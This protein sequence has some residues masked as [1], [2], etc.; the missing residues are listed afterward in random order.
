[1][2]D[3]ITSVLALVEQADDFPKM[4][5]AQ[6]G[7]FRARITTYLKK[8]GDSDPELK[9]ILLDLES[10]VGKADPK[11][12]AKLTVEDLE[13]QARDYANIDPKSRP[14]FKANISRLLKEA[15]SKEDK[16][17]IKRLKTLQN[18][19]DSFEKKEKMEALLKAVES[20]KKAD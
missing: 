16:P 7:A 8:V 20:R 3:L 6:Q 17:A 14:P 18:S 10:E 9:Q 1:M 4:S 11:G 15:E 13:K 12:K 2:S 19:I 5:P